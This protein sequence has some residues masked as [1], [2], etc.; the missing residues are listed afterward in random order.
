MHIRVFES[1]L[2]VPASEW[3][4]LADN[5]N[6]FLRH[7]FLSALERSGSAAPERGWFPRPLVLYETAGEPIGAVPLWL[8][9]HS[10]GE[11]VYDFAWADAYARAGLAYYPK[12]I[13][14]LPFSPVA[15]PRLLTSPGQ[16]RAEI[17]GPLIEAAQQLAVDLG[18]SSLHWLFTDQ[19][20][21]T[22]LVEHG[23]LHRTGVQFHWRNGS[24]GSFDDF[25]STFT[26]DK[27]KKLKRERRHVTD[28]GISMAVRHGQDL[29]SDD[30][31]AFYALYTA[32]I[33]RHGGMVHLTREFFSLLA[34]SL[35]NAI[36]LVEARRGRELVG[37]AFNLRGT[38]SLYGRYWGGLPGIPNLHFETCYYSAIE[39]CI[40][41]GL[42][43]FEGGAGGEHKLARGLEPTVTHSAHW[44]RHPQFSEAVAQFLIRE[45]RG[46][47]NY[48]DELNEHAPYRMP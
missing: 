25:L 20:D 34:E 41:H 19:R 27:R 28:A 40:A 36:V 1:Y 30:W 5:E 24:Y 39:Y 35:P 9:N 22:L 4:R 6:P 7:E 10:F 43:V 2:D 21:T 48:V 29:S 18:A 32:N 11:L 3:N 8:K 37:A 12:L 31:D 14:A 47:S 17:E 26:S 38:R 13:A 46:I 45:Q 15:G 44:L 16:Q 23:F 42:E 33:E